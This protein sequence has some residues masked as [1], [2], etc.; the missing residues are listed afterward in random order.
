MDKRINLIIFLLLIPIG[1]AL[2]ANYEWLMNPYTRTL[3][4]TIKLNQTGY[5]LTA[6]H[7]FGILVGINATINQTV[8]LSFVPYTGAYKTIEIGGWDILGS[9]SDGFFC[10]CFCF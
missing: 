10:F 6:D 8:N 1:S 2:N 5:N 4:R 3:D 9:F 7:F